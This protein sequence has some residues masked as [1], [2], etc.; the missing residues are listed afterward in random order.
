MVGNGHQ[1]PMA[2]QWNDEDTICAVSTPPGVGGIAVIRVSGGQSL[3]FA[4]KVCPFIP[5]RPESHRIYYGHAR[6]VQSNE[7]IDEV[8]ASYFGHGQSFTGEATV[9]ISCHGSPML[10]GQILQNLIAAG[11]RSAN[12]GEF[13]YRAFANGRLDLVQA[14]SVLSLIES[15]SKKTSRIALRQLEGELSQTLGEI[16]NAL[17]WLLAHLEAS[18]D[19]STENLEIVAGEVMQK[20]AEQALQKLQSLCESY[21]SGRILR[22]GLNVVLLGR[23][24]VGK[25]SFL[26]K[27]V[28]LERSIV[29]EIAGTTRDLVEGELSFDGITVRVIDT[30]GLQQTQDKVEKIGIQRALAAAAMADVVFYL[31]DLQE[32]DWI[33]DY[34]R[35]RQ[36]ENPFVVFNKHDLAKPELDI[37]W[38]TRQVSLAIGKDINKCSAVVSALTGQ[39]LDQVR[40][41]LKQVCQSSHSDQGSVILQVRQFELLSKASV[42]VE[43][44]LNLLRTQA[45][46][47][48]IAFDLTEALRSMHELLGKS[49]DEQVIDRVFKE[50]CLGK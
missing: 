33:E 16:E 43:R 27:L 26:N 37:D 22:D 25:S 20:K 30:A 5:E 46:P 36:L 13:T 10:A 18:I 49:F 45:S 17:T 21:E 34:S 31:L 29:T 2:S 7:A 11:C 44:A 40:A 1:K 19:F 50:F 38:L 47:E 32:Q 41:F 39:G 48:F 4:Q 23:P 6:E 12:P 9:E 24:N 35:L 15:R 3:S 28:G 8:L 42:S 14:E